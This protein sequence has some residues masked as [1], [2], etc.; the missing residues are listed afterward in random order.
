MISKLLDK[1]LFDWSVNFFYKLI[2]ANPK[3]RF[4][5][6]VDKILSKDYDEKT[7]KSY[8]TMDWVLG[9][10]LWFYVFFSFGFL[11]TAYNR[12]EPPKLNEMQ[13]LEGKI[14]ETNKYTVEKDLDYKE[15]KFLDK[16]NT[17]HTLLFRTS[18]DN[19]YEQYSNLINQ[20]VKVWVW[21][22]RFDISWIKQIQYPNE[23]YFL[24][25]DYL[26]EK[27]NYD[28]G[29]SSYYK[30][31]YLKWG[32]GALALLILKVILSRL[33]IKRYKYLLVKFRK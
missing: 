25:Y 8:D 11:M 5:K 18:Y 33:I 15:L 4:V 32:G 28:Y 20:D 22:K 19:T 2:F 29:T 13:F 7:R 16:N 1:L 23:K 9:I 10:A 12:I 24:K 21:Q 30:N 6:F 26:K 17:T 31:T 27:Q 3:N 14:I